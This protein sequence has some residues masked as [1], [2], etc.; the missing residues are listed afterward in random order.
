MIINNKRSAF[1]LARRGSA[2][3]QFIQNKANEVPQTN[4]IKASPYSMVNSVDS[5]RP[6]SQ[7]LAS[8]CSS[9]YADLRIS[10]QITPSCESVKI[11]HCGRMRRSPPA[12]YKAVTIFM[13]FFSVPNEAPDN[14]RVEYVDWKSIIIEWDPVPKG[15]ENGII[16]GYLVQYGEPQSQMR[17]QSISGFR[18]VLDGVQHNIS[19]VIQVAAFTSL[20]VGRY[21]EPLSIRTKVCKY[22]IVY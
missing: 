18:A 8:R 12:L 13:P 6:I 10:R 5:L 20:G 3:F 19:Y 1:E 11:M 14:V 9:V 15:S 7:P 16:Q 17:N 4:S 22:H 21:S 2:H